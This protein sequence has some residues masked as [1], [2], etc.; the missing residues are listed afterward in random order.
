[1]RESNEGARP[2]SSADENTPRS[3]APRPLIPVFSDQDSGVRGEPTTAQAVA[4]QSLPKDQSPWKT[5]REWAAIGLS[6]LALLVSFGSFLNSRSS[7]DTARAQFDATR[8]LVLV[9]EKE[10]PESSFDVQLFRFHPLS[11]T[12]RLAGVRITV[13]TALKTKP[14]ETAPSNQTLTLFPITMEVGE[15][16]VQR[17][18]PKAGFAQLLVTTIPVVLEAQYATP[19]ESLIHRGLYYLSAYVTVREK[20]PPIVEFNDFFFLQNIGMNV[21]ATALV[22]GEFS[23][24]QVTG[25]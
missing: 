18:P 8:A 17:H 15:Y 23:K 21:D 20:D 25:R 2:A 24:T 22:D 1:M 12:Q 14:W 7:A 13:P 19:G 16:Y 3:T 10:K 11:T 4:L 9:A 5:A 6:L